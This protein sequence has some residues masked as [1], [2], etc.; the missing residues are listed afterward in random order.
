MFGVMQDIT[1][2]KQA[3][4][5]LIRYRDSLERLARE[6]EALRRVATLVARASAP[7][8]DLRPA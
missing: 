5:R 3:E 6:Q 4:E 7:E 1:E 2:R 8:D